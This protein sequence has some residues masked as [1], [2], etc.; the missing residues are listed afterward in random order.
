MP[1][2]E[3]P[4]SLPRGVAPSLASTHWVPGAPSPLVTLHSPACLQTLPDVPWGPKGAPPTPVQV[5]LRQTQRIITTI[6]PRDSTAKVQ[7]CPQA[8]PTIRFF[9]KMKNNPSSCS[10]GNQGCASGLQASKWFRAT[11]CVERQTGSTEQTRDPC[12][13][14]RKKLRQKPRASAKW[15]EGRPHPNP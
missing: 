6:C 8:A 13:F 15:G 7:A 3:Q 11:L 1:V 9:S 12:R 4:C 14:H 10:K 2:R 5:A